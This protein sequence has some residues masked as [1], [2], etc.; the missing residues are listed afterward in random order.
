MSKKYEM[1]HEEFVFRCLNAAANLYGVLK[2]EEFVGLCDGYLKAHKNLLTDPLTPEVVKIIADERIREEENEFTEGGGIADEV[3]FRLWTHSKTGEQFVV[4]RDIV[5]DAEFDEETDDIDVE[6]VEEAIDRRRRAWAV[7]NIKVLPEKAFLDYEEPMFAEESEECE[8]LADLFGAD[9][10]RDDELDMPSYDASAVQSHMRLNGAK[11]TTAL[12]YISDCL[13]YR[14]LDEDEYMEWINVLSKLV[15]VTRTWDYRGHTEHELTKMGVLKRIQSEQIPAFESVFGEGNDSDE[16]LDDEDD[17]DGD[18]GE[19]YEDEEDEPFSY[20]TKPEVDLAALPP[21]EFVGPVDFKFV[22]DAERREKIVSDYQAVR[23]LTQDFVRRIVMHEMTSQERK[24]AAKRLG[25]DK[26]PVKGGFFGNTVGNRDIVAG[27]FGSMMDDQNGEP[28]IKRVLAKLETL[29]ERDRRAAAYYANYRY[30][31][32]EVQAVKAGVGLKC[33]D[34]LT[35]EDLFLMEMSASQNPN[36]KGMTFCA[37]IAPIGMVYMTVGVLHPANF[38]NPAT[39]L[40]IVLTH[41]KLPTE[42]PVRLSFADQAR[43]AAE[44]IRR[45]DANGKFGSIHY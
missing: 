14:P 42:L 37:G 13:E 34:L 16:W 41:L 7:P 31:W 44:T 1:T 23:A 26:S 27:D 8:A 19:D 12:E 22:K 29:D 38:E 45:L 4:Y 5:E 24:D 15:N 33:R 3:W 39:I 21:A 10:S 2:M 32:L 6:E 35:G 9:G 11:L 17:E 25:F 28:A 20:E 43:F 30:T 18:D 40:K 36:A